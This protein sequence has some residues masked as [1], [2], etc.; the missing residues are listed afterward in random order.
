MNMISIDQLIRSRRKTI[1]LIV[2]REARLVVRAPLRAS[3]AQIDAVV[4]EKAVWIRNRQAE[5]LARPRPPALDFKEGASFPYQGRLYPLRFS[6]RAPLRLALR[7]GV[8][9]LSP[10][11]APQAKRYFL[12]WYKRQARIVLQ[13]RVKFHAS[14]LGLD[15]AALRISSA[16]T[17]W[18]SCS[19]RGTLS[20]TWR[21]VL[22]P[23]A[24]IDYVVVHELV[25]LEIKNHSRVFWQRVQAAYP[26][27]L[28]ARRWLKE[29]SHIGEE[30]E[31]GWK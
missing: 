17:R 11:R 19:S 21:L 26:E 31:P 25:H 16:R 8:F 24:V 15:P 30:F 4:A 18:G 12:A 28:A 6:P 10:A 1:V 5:M 22:A 3:R 14:R 29:N 23:Q 13:D 27:T 9:Q 20:F 2:T 7:D